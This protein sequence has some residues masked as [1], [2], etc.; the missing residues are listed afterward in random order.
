M[1]KLGPRSHFPS[2]LQAWLPVMQ[3]DPFAILALV[4]GCSNIISQYV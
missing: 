2:R 1:T 3:P 4:A